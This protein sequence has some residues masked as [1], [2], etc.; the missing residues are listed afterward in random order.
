M[1]LFGPPG[2]GKTTLAHIIALEMGAPIQVTSGPVL[3]RAGDLAAILTNIEPGGVLFVDEIHR[4]APAVA[5]I[6]YPALE[7]F[8]LDLVVGQGPAA[9]T[10][11]LTLPPF[12]LVGATTRAGLLPPPLRDRFGIVH[13]LDFYAHDA[14]TTIVRRSAGA[15]RH[16][17]RRRR[18][19]GD[20]PPLAGHAAYRQPAA[21]AR[22]R[23]RPRRR[24][25]RHHRSRSPAT[26]S[27]ASRSTPSAST[28]S[29]AGCWLP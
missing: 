12:T 23:L 17:P 9:R 4:M 14:L 26:D 13:R 11:R 25:R 5:E 28:T 29:T 22:A 10:M 1:L 24:R 16:R 21:A 20:R 7:D 6:L 19:R 2:L 8:A 3:E 15:A 27:S 18:G